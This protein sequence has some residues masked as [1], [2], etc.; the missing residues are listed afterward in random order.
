MHHMHCGRRAESASDGDSGDD[1]TEEEGDEEEEEEN[2]KEEEGDEER[3]GGVGAVRERVLTV[4][5]LFKRLGRYM[6]DRREAVAPL[7]VG[8]LQWLAAA[9]RRLGAARLSAHGGALVAAA[10]TPLFRLQDGAALDGEEARPLTA[11]LHPAARCRRRACM[12]HSTA[13]T[14][15]CITVALCQCESRW[16]R[17]RSGPRRWQRCYGTRLGRRRWRQ[18]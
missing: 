1:G 14:P 11:C 6:V 2:D 10:A 17:S 13:S 3:Q 16:C 8:A 12:Q 4:R 15:A 18:R 7:R 9:L 5:G